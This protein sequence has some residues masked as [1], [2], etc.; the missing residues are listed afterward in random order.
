MAKDDER[1]I[2]YDVVARVSEASQIP[3]PDDALGHELF[4]QG[5]LARALQLPVG[6][7]VALHGDW[8]SGKT[9]ILARMARQVRRNEPVKVADI[10][11]LNPW[12]YSSAD[13]LGPLVS[14]LLERAKSQKHVDWGRVLPAARAIVEAGVNFG[15]KALGHFVPGF[16]ILDKAADAAERLI[17]GVVDVAKAQ[18]CTAEGLAGADPVAQMAEQFRQ[19]IDH[20]CDTRDGRPVIICID[21]LDR[22]L[23]D[24]QVAL[25]EAVKFLLAAQARVI[26]FVALDPRL[27]REAIRTRYRLQEFDADQYL[28]KMFHLRLNVPSMNERAHAALVRSLVQR[29]AV[30]PE[31]RRAMVDVVSAAEGVIG[32]ILQALRVVNPR[33]VEKIVVKA[34]Y[35]LGAA[36]RWSEESAVPIQSERFW[37]LISYV[38]IA[39][40]WPQYRRAIFQNRIVAEGVRFRA[41]D[42]ELS[43]GLSQ[44]LAAAL[45]GT[46]FEIPRL[47]DEYRSLD[48]DFARIGL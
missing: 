5:L 40:R 29:F 22:C 38:I 33:F 21:D 36:P 19:L 3:L 45:E 44:I 14:L 30:G 41:D 17:A 2:T 39:E 42:A 6:S 4:A 37:V 7:V 28:D 23:P 32:K 31:D 13:L 34:L 43:D 16:E 46:A 9:D 12:Q 24:R 25:L 15:C 20:T 1:N 8:G 35:Y 48:A 47:Q 27:A 10:F 11:W 26:F 18:A